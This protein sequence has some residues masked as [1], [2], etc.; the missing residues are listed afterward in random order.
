MGKNFLAIASPSDCILLSSLTI[1]DSPVRFA[2]TS[3][4]PSLPS[5]LCQE[6]NGAGA[7]GGTAEN[8]RSVPVLLAD[9]HVEL[10]PMPVFHSTKPNP[11]TTNSISDL[12]WNE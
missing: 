11:D 5:P 4:Q 3:I 8:G 9:L 2:S 7:E 6:S 1:E 10:M 12:R